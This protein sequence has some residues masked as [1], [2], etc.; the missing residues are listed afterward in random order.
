M[1]ADVTNTPWGERHAYVLDPDGGRSAK[2][3]H[4]SPFLDME[5]EYECRA[6]APGETT[7]ASVSSRRDGETVFEATLLLR[8]RE[9]TRA[10]LARMLARYPLQGVQIRARIYSQA[11]RLRLRGAR[12]FPHPGREGVA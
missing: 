2:R 12:Y 10:G 9:L 11:L 5:Q 4:V 6:Q 7:R 8:R 1:V 3:L